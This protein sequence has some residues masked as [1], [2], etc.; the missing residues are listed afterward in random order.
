MTLYQQLNLCR[1]ELKE[2]DTS[3][4]QWEGTATADVKSDNILEVLK[5]NT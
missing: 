3:V 2:N 1:F 4:R 5:K